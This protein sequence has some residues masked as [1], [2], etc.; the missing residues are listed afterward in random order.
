MISKK[1]QIGVSTP[2][3]IVPHKTGI[4]YNNQVGGYSVHDLEIEG[5]LIPLEPYF[6]VKKKEGKKS[7]NA[8]NPYWDKVNLQEYFDKLF[9]PLK[10]ITKYQGHGYHGI[11][12]KDVKYLEKALKNEFLGIQIDRMKLKECEEAKIFVKIQLEQYEDNKKIKPILTKG[13]LTWGNSD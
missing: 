2:C 4:F 13:V 3:I 1:I 11:D 8:E 9:A 12:L 7:N 6:Y 10:E 5:Y